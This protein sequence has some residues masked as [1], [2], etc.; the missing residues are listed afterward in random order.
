MNKKLK[1]GVP[2]SEREKPE[3]TQIK[4]I[5]DDPLPVDQDHPGWQN[6]TP[7][8]QD[9]LNDLQSKQDQGKAMS[10]KDQAALDNLKDIVRDGRPI[11]ENHPGFENLGPDEQ[12]SLKDLL[13][14]IESGKVL[15][16]EENQEIGKLEDKVI[17]G[18]PLDDAHP[19]I[20]K[21][22]CPSDQKALKDLINREEPLSNEEEAKFDALKNMVAKGETLDSSHPGMVNLSPD[23]QK[24]LED[25]ESKLDSGKRLTSEYKKDLDD[26]KEALAHGQPLN[27]NHPGIDNL[28]E[29]EKDQLKAI[30]D[31]EPEGLSP[32]EKALDDKLKN[33]M[34]TG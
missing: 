3:L 11:D 16:H 7:S 9:Q 24:Q 26:L 8:E 32:K 25:I 1:S 5:M 33:I 13:G 29:N 10:P 21:T 23:Q 12:D 14:K 15:S 17:N 19:D 30:E 22:L 27:S 4:D 6:L 34:A 2:L 28:T 31:K 20:E 18:I